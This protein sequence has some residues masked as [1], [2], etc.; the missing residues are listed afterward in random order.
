MKYHETGEKKKKKKSDTLLL[1]RHFE[2]EW[3]FLLLNAISFT[4]LLQAATFNN[5]KINISFVYLDR[6]FSTSASP[7]ACVCTR[8]GLCAL[9]AMIATMFYTV[10]AILILQTTFALR[11][12]VVSY[13]HI[14]FGSLV[15]NIHRYSRGTSSSI[16]MV[17]HLRTTSMTSLYTLFNIH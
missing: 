1:L 12:A 2:I 17:I 14:R 9:P 3:N 11:A 16:S 8:S 7:K 13:S 6:I 4:I 10:A 5:E 15:P